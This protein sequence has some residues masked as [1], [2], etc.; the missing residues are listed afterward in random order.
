MEIDNLYPSKNTK[1]DNEV[2]PL[3]KSKFSYLNFKLNDNLITINIDK[4][5]KYFRCKFTN[6]DEAENIYKSI[7][8]AEYSNKIL[9]IKDINNAIV[10]FQDTLVYIIDNNKFIFTQEDFILFKVENNLLLHCNNDIYIPMSN[11]D[12]QTAM[13]YEYLLNNKIIQYSITKKDNFIIL[14]IDIPNR[15]IKYTFIYYK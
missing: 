15:I 1:L 5:N 2:K 8:K 10:R 12:I 4:T 7:Q 13:V 11:I 3:V 9:D 14:I 6:K